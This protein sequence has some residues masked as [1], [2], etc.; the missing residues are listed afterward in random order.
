MATLKDRTDIAVPLHRRNFVLNVVNGALSM[1]SMRLADTSTVLPLLVLKLA[2]AEWAVGLLQAVQDFGRV[3]IQVFVARHLDSVPR[4]MPVYVWGSVARIVSLGVCTAALLYGV[5][6]DPMLVLVAFL[7]S[8]FVWMLLNGITELAWM[9]ITARSVPSVRR[10]SMMTGRKS[11]GIILALL[12][13]TPVVN[14]YLGPQCPMQFPANYGAL[15]V[16]SLLFFAGAWGVFCLVREPA[17]HAAKRRLSVRHH[18]ARGLRVFQRDP[19]YQRLQWFRLLMGAAQAFP[20]FFIAFGKIALALPDQ[21]AATF[22]GLKLVSEMVASIV[23]GRVSDRLGNRAV[24]VGTSVVSVLTFGAAALCAWLHLLAGPG[25]PAPTSAVVLLGAVFVGF[26]VLQSGRETGE[27]NYLLDIAPASKRPSYIGF[28]NAFLLPLSLLPLAIGAAIP[29]VGYLP[30]FACA[31]AFSAAA[32]WV[33]LRM[34]EPREVF[35][36]GP[37]GADG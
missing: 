9:D 4:K 13:A 32:L 31:T 29:A 28:G 35:M 36:A 17:A 10:G 8:L 33:S 6:R 34:A 20:A 24:I 26:G 15:H 22:L 2:G 30:I 27:F 23:F 25:A 7:A 19:L 16:A 37:E 5:D 18:F 14:Y 12:I 3:A 1:V 11:I 21:A